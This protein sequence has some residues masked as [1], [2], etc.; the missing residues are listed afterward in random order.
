MARTELPQRPLVQQALDELQWLASH[1][2]AAYPS[3]RIGFDL[4]DMSGYAYY[5]GSRFAVYGA[6][7]SEALA[8]GGRYDEVGAVFG[9]NRPAEDRPHLVVAATTR[10]RLH[11]AG[12][13]DR[14]ARAAVVGVAAHV[15]QVKANAQRRIGCAQMAG[16]PACSSSSACCTSGRW[17]ARC[18]PPAAPHRRHTAAAAP[19]GPVALHPGRRASLASAGASFSDSACTTSCKAAASFATPA[20]TQRNTRASARSMTSGSARARPPGNP[21]P[22]RQLR[23]RLP[24]PDR[25]KISARGRRSYQQHAQ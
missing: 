22:V 25:P 5:S 21:A 10:Q 20:S 24:G 17:A 14:K 8:R 3:L 16:Q 15:G 23:G 7:S 12:A 6:G 2:R 11:A 9:R 4:S 13:V 19:A 1:L 18:A